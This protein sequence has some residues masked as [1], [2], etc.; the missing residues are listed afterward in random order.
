MNYLDKRNKILDK[1]KGISIIAVIIIHTHPFKNPNLDKRILTEIIINQAC[2][3]AVPIFFI[4]SGI[5]YFNKLNENNAPIKCALKRFL[6]LMKIFLIWNFIYLFV[7]LNY[8][9]ILNYGYIKLI[10]WKLHF[11]SN[12]LNFFLI[13]SA[14]HLWFIPSLS[15]G[16]VFCT[17]LHVYTQKNLL[18]ITFLFY[19]I[20]LILGPYEGLHGFNLPT[21]D[22]RIG[23]Y[24]SSIFIAIGFL[25]IKNTNRMFVSKRNLILLILIFIFFHFIEILYLYLTTNHDL[26]TIDY[27]LSLLPLNTLVYI[28]IIKYSIKIP[29]I[30]SYIGEKSF[31]I[32]LVHMLYVEIIKNFTFINMHLYAL[33]GPFLVLIFSILTVNLY[34]RLKALK[35]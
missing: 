33:L 5:L 32:Y 2:R 3:F 8:E 23:I 35:K 7:S 22:T 16:I 24:F 4:T 13:G 14:P 34:Q 27:T 19:I 26:T 20:G 12:P 9:N 17:I 29:N 31:G 6:F 30:F 15:L 11:I 25:L 1:L 21:F 18:L 10:Y 28:Y